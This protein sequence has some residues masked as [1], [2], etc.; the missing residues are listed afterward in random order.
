MVRPS[1]AG[2][3]FCLRSEFHGGGPVLGL[4]CTPVPTGLSMNVL[5]LVSTIA[6][7]FILGSC[8]SGT[9]DTSASDVDA[10]PTLAGHVLLPD[11]TENRGVEVVV[12]FAIPDPDRERQWVL[13]GADGHFEKELYGQPIRVVVTTGHGVL[14]R[15]EEDELPAV[16]AAGR[17]DLGEIDLRD[18][19]EPHRFVVRAAEGRPEGVVRVAMWWG[20]APPAGVALGSRQFPPVPLGTELEWLLPPDATDV[21]FLVERPADLSG[22][23]EWRAGEQYRFGPFTAA[24]VPAELVV[25]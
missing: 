21:H 9:P 5:V 12:T 14:R 19:L 15:Y 24:T 16:D 2:S 10:P 25:D 4:P 13:F 7:S 11:V 3:P 1:G 8:R 6:L 17:I 20:S 18:A 23:Q 22:E